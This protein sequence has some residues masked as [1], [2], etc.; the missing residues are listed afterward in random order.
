MK[1]A[2]LDLFSQ[3]VKTTEK[4]ASPAFLDTTEPQTNNRAKPKIDRESIE[5]GLQEILGHREK[6]RPGT[7]Y[8]EPAKVKVKIDRDITTPTSI[9]YTDDLIIVY[10]NPKRIRTKAQ[11]DKQLD[12]LRKE[13]AKEANYE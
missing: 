10:L 4:P 3:P 1:T 8:T 12:Y 5:R 13:M 2:Q 7:Y 11:L 9:R 6:G